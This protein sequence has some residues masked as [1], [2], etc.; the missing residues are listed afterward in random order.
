ME[1]FAGMWLTFGFHKPSVCWHTTTVGLCHLK[2][3]EIIHSTNT[4]KFSDV[5]ILTH[6]ITDCVWSVLFKWRVCHNKTFLIYF[7]RYGT[8]FYHF[9]EWQE[10]A[11][12]YFQFGCVFKGMHRR[13]KERKKTHKKVH[14]YATHSALKTTVGLINT[15]LVIPE[16]L[17]RS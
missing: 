15:T 4:S 3:C 6:I 7:E 10:G 14:K 17:L 11:E 13:K 8:S 9:C 2:F 16:L 12:F 5:Q 1:Q